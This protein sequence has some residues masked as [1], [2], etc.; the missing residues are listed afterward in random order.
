MPKTGQISEILLLCG[1]EV[2]LQYIS[3]QSDLLSFV[4]IPSQAADYI[5][6]SL[7]FNKEQDNGKGQFW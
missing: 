1:I 5:K 6:K 4:F 2:M 7:V 3:P